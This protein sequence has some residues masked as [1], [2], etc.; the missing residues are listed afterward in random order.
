MHCSHLPHVQQC[1]LLKA[2]AFG[3]YT[4]LYTFLI[5][6]M[7]AFLRTDKH[8]S[9]MQ[10]GLTRVYAVKDEPLKWLEQLGDSRAE[11]LRQLP[12]SLSIPSLKLLVVHAGLIP[13]IPLSQQSLKT[14]TEVGLLTVLQAAP[15]MHQLCRI[16][17][18]VGSNFAPTV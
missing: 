18:H 11:W 3:L 7:Q 4:L 2:C 17:Y 1:L 5:A 15:H 9:T 13:G 12:F 14:L 10:A 16:L 8:S 6:D